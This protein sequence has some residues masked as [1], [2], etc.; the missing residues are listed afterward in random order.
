MLSRFWIMLLLPKA[1]D[2]AYGIVDLSTQCG[3]VPHTFNAPLK[4]VLQ[5]L[6]FADLSFTCKFQ[7]N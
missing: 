7:T 6:M 4:V 1:K 5:W 2:N 3:F